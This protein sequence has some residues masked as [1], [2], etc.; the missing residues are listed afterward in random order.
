MLRRFGLHLRDQW[1]GA[2]ALFLVLAGGTAY[3]VD[4]S[5]PGQNTVGSDDIINN[6][7]KSADIADGRI[8]NVDLADNLI[9][10]QKM[11]DGTLTGADVE[12]SSLTR[13][14]IANN[15]LTD[16]DIADGTLTGDDVEDGTL[17]A[18]D[19][20]PSV[21]LPKVFAILDAP[22]VSDTN[23]PLAYNR[24]VTSLSRMGT[25]AYCLEANTGGVEVVG[26]V[27]PRY[28]EEVEA[29]AVPAC[30]ESGPGSYIVG[31]RID[32]VQSNEVPFWIAIY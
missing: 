3:A 24:G 11:K 10:G 12:N 27:D 19:L 2:A 5:L 14:D 25:G 17:G 32:N 26:L 9:T 7:V 15:S 30:G 29:T 23:C 21:P 20:G 28:E 31:T 4:G 13:D 22:C 16:D 1:M 6:D 18:A 8:F